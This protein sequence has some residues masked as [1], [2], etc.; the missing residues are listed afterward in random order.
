MPLAPFLAAFSRAV[1]KACSIF[2]TST[3][4][5]AAALALRSWSRS[6]SLAMHLATAAR[7]PSVSPPHLTAASFMAAAKPKLASLATIQAAMAGSL[8]AKFSQLP[9]PL[10]LWRSRLCSRA[11][12]LAS[13]DDLKLRPPL[14]LQLKQVPKCRYWPE[15]PHL[16]QLSKKARWSA[17]T[18]HCG[19]GA[20]LAPSTL[21]PKTSSRSSFVFMIV[22]L[23][24][25]QTAEGI[26]TM[27][28]LDTSP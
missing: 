3:T 19:A 8:S 2:E 26:W 17:L 6:A 22:P 14:P 9:V 18:A 15:P 1:A 13:G 11:L 4:G 16:P 10:A 5:A 21:A 23:C 28:L 25:A 24:A 7:W 12:A 27:R 20:R